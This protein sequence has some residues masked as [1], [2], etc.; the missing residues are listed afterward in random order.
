M[1]YGVQGLIFGIL[2]LGGVII[3]VL[4]A[5][6]GALHI[7]ARVMKAVFDWPADKNSKTDTNASGDA[8]RSA[9]PSGGED[10]TSPKLIEAPLPFV[11]GGPVYRYPATDGPTPHERART[12]AREWCAEFARELGDAS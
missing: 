11:P 1:G 6:F 2:M 9:R 4:V 5:L 8:A 3:G 12:M 7:F 10:E